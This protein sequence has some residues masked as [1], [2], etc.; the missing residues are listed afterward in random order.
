MY[1][2]WNDAVT[3]DIISKIAGIRI[4]PVMDYEIGH[5]NLSENIHP[6][7]NFLLAKSISQNSLGEKVCPIEFISEDQLDISTR[8]NL[9]VQWHKDAY[10]FVC[11]VSLTSQEERGRGGETILQQG[12]GNVLIVPSPPKGHAIVLQGKHVAHAALRLQYKNSRRITMVTSFRP[13]D[14]FLPDECDLT[15]VKQSSNGAQLYTDYVE[16]KMDVLLKRVISIKSR[17]STEKAKG[18]TLDVKKTEECIES[19]QIFLQNLRSQT[20]EGFESELSTKMSATCSKDT[21]T[22]LENKIA[23]VEDDKQR[24]E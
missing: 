1:S 7:D 4:K 19:L 13:E 11:I 24:G 2:A 17:V 15:N 6:G 23:Q 18:K 12:D 16:Y 20:G 5:V 3:L 8:E 9:A 14:P 10:P 21:E 22:T